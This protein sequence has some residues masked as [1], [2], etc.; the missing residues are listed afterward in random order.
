MLITNFYFYRTVLLNYSF[1]FLEFCSSSWILFPSYFFTFSNFS[2]DI[3]NS[4]SFSFFHICSFLLSSIFHSSI[5]LSFLTICFLKLL[6]SSLSFIS[7][8]SDS[9]D[10]FNNSS[11]FTKL[12]FGRDSDF[13]LIAFYFSSSYFSKELIFKF[14]NF[15][16]SF[17]ISTSFSYF[18]TICFFSFS[19]SSFSSS[20]STSNV[21]LLLSCVDLWSDI[22]LFS[23]FNIL[24]SWNTL[25]VSIILYLSI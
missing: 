21:P 19:S 6:I 3:F 11:S 13:S 7:F 9:F 18:W 1:Y 16:S 25:L 20:L 10:T 4:S 24:A 22:F 23:S 5:E 17:N 12:F 15:L 8:Y 2:D 14:N